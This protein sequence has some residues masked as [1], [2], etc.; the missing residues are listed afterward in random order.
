MITFIIVLKLSTLLAVM[1]FPVIG[2]KKQKE[3]LK[4][5]SNLFVN[6]YGYLEY[7]T[8]NSSIDHY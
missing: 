1:L 6:Q 5:L 8:G 4:G 2:P 7:I 3:S